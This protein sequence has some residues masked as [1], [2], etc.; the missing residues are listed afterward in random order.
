[1]AIFRTQVFYSHPSLGKWSNVYHVSAANLLTA[2]VA[3]EG[4][5]VPE[6]LQILNTACT[7]IGLLVSALDS[8]DFS[9][10]ALNLPGEDAGGGTLLPLFNSVKVLIQPANLGRPDVKFV[11]GFLTEDTHSAG[12]CT[13][14]AQ[15]AVDAAFTT[16]IGAMDLN[17][18]PLVSEDG[19]EWVS[20]SV[21]GA[22]QMRQMHRRRRRP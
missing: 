18:T 15:T 2:R 20:A 22:V 1:V 10:L 9:E 3:F 19:A 11:K 13:S 17:T 6:L 8:D 14:G 5:V 4:N 12:S 7:L 16:F 21:Q